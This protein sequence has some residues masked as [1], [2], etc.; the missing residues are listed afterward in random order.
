MVDL[1]LLA[2]RVLIKSPPPSALLAEGPPPCRPARVVAGRWLAGLDVRLARAVLLAQGIVCA[3]PPIYALALVAGLVLGAWHWLG[4]AVSGLSNAQF[5]NLG[6]F[7][8]G[9]R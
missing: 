6:V 4:F 3:H 1:L 8:R 2:L 7:S 5:L 9:F